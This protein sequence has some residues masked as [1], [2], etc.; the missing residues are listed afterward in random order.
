MYWEMNL[1]VLV[2][3]PSEPED[4]AAIDS[5]AETLFDR[6]VSSS[7]CPTPWIALNEL[8]GSRLGGPWS[9]TNETYR[10]NVL[11]LMSHL[12]G[13]GAHPFLLVPGVPRDRGRGGRL[14]GRRRQR[15]L[16]RGARSTSARP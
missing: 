2:G 6:A 16:A 11:E 4:P 13:L 9:V 5:A 7:G 14:V 10:A 3:T 15:R 12:T 1:D 8:Q